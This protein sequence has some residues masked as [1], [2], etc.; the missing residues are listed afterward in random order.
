MINEIKKNYLR[1]LSNV[2]SFKERWSIWGPQIRK[3]LGEEPSGEDIF[4]L[5][6]GLN[7]IFFPEEKNSKIERGQEEVSQIGNA[8]KSFNIW[9]LNLLFWGTPILAMKQSKKFTP[10]VI[11]DCITVDIS[12]MHINSDSNILIFNIPNHQLLKDS[13]SLNQHI[14]ENISN[15]ELIMLQSK[16]NW[17]DTVQETMLWDIIY[18]AEGLP[19]YVKVG[20]NDFCPQN[21][22]SFKYAFTTWPTGTRKEIEPDSMPVKRVENLTGG[23]FWLKETKQDVAANIKELPYRHFSRFYPEE[24]VPSHIEEIREKDKEFLSSFLDLNW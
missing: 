24:G 16:T 3:I 9:F 13:N 2:N 19:D 10:K 23:N 18:N 21:L 11:R 15:V 7:G 12:K 5:V 14:E 17:S 8:F 1:S 22:H 20:I 4:N 6:E